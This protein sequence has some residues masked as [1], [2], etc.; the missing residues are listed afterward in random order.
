MKAA[1][2]PNAAEAVPEFLGKHAET[3]RFLQ[4]PKLSP[5]SFA[6]EKFFGVNA[7]RFVKEGKVTTL[8][9]RIVPVAGEQHL[10]AEDLKAKSTTYLFDEFPKRLESGPIEFKLVAQIA[11]DGDVTD[12]ATEIWPEE[13]KLVELGTIKVEKPLSDEESLKEQKNIIFDPIPRVDGVEPSDDPLLDV[14]A[15]IY[16]ITGKQR[17]ETKDEPSAVD[18]T[19]PTA[20]AKAA[21]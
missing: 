6:T 5:V 3:V 12:N 2:G 16:L 4:D 21:T 11:E 18:V 19:A 8:R 7:F 15:T 1:G 20:A 13:R 14:R 17:R 10:S 9:Y